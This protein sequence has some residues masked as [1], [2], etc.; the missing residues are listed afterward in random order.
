MNVFALIVIHG[1]I[2]AVIG[3]LP[4]DM[5]TC[6][7]RI[8]EMAADVGRNVRPMDLRGTWTTREDVT[9]VCVYAKERPVVYGVYAPGEPS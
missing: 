4:Y 6:N 5:N 1:V 2:E 9:Q 7:V 8:A 3:P